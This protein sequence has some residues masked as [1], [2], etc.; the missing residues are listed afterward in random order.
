MYN[1]KPLSIN[2]TEY[3]RN[4][5]T[6]VDRATHLATNMTEALQL[7]YAFAATRGVSPD[8]IVIE[9]YSSDVQHEQHKPFSA[10]LN[11]H[12]AKAKTFSGSG[13]KL[14]TL[15]L[16]A[17]YKKGTYQ[18][19]SD[20]N[21]L[22]VRPDVGVQ[23]LTSLK[24]GNKIRRKTDKSGIKDYLNKMQSSEPTHSVYF[25]QSA[26]WGKGKS[27]I[28]DVPQYKERN[29]GVNQTQHFHEK[30]EKLGT[31]A[32]VSMEDVL[33]ESLRKKGL[34]K[35]KLRIYLRGNGFSASH[36]QAIVNAL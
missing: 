21:P 1:G 27:V 22:S 17:R 25:A 15:E 9:P 4:G 14:N 13:L 10:N 26:E 34:G 31:R 7:K 35:K 29:S 24:T 11:R 6:L 2:T 3:V 33:L 8:L 16:P 5:D 18:G 12:L 36:A 28:M 30:I 32:S 23:V 20:N 19:K